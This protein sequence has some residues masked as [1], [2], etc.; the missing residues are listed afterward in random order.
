MILDYPGKRSNKKTR[1][2]KAQTMSLEDAAIYDLIFNDVP[3]RSVGKRIDLSYQGVY[4]RALDYM[5]LWVS[6]GIL[7]FDK[8]Y[9]KEL[10]K[11]GEAMSPPA[12]AE[13]E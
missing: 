10:E 12:T 13:E 7:K 3:L 1:L 5:K 4:I 6:L 9:L 11:K 8:K 2:L